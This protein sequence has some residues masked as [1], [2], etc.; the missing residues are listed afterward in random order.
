MKKLI[1]YII[2]LSI[3]ATHVI[4]NDS[5]GFAVIEPRPLANNSKIKIY[6]YQEDVIYRYVGTYEFQSH[7]KFQTGEEIKTISMGNTS[8]WEMIPSGNRLFLRPLNSR[9]KTNMTLITNRRLYQFLLDATSAKSFADKD[10]IFEARFLYPDD[11]SGFTVI[12]EDDSSEIIDLSQPEKYNFNYSFSGPDKIAPV[13]VLDDGEFTY[14]Q[15]K[16]K[17]AEIP[18]IFYVD[19]DGYEGLVNYRVKGDYI[20]VERVATMFTLRHG[21]DTICVFNEMLYKKPQKK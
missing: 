11:N 1:S 8:G 2:I 9:A 14:F 17:N 16:A 4:A 5:Q 19:S 12:S 20:V 21:T 18:A 3:Y 7:I 13:K 10:A 6:S 15:F